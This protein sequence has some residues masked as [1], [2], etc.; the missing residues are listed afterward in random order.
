MNEENRAVLAEALVHNYITD[1]DSPVAALAGVDLEIRKGEFVCIIGPNGSGKSTLARHINALLLP[2]EG[3]VVVFGMDTRDE[4][5][6]WEIRRTAG[7]VFQNPDNQMV[8]TVVEEDVAFGPENLG[9]DPDEIRRRVSE[10]L[11]AVGMEEF[12]RASPH[13]LSGGQKQRVAIAGVLAM[14]PA[15]IV[16]DEPTAML[17]P[18][19]RKE[20]IDTLSRLNKEKGI[21]V[22][23]ITHHM[24]EAVCA[25]RVIVMYEGRIALSG[26][27]PEVFSRIDDLTK[28]GLDAPFVEKLG[29]ILRKNG[30]QVSESALT[31]E[32]MVDELCRLRSTT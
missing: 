9:I 24:D 7:M 21:T 23:H 13:F 2:T 28:W 25:D 19:G 26:S 5:N 17:D 1:D 31:V 16:L 30:Y 20:V 14:M 3:R 22:I 32:E 10:A 4:R 8:A 15:V 27:P 12:A 29:D 18:K 6:L 11:R